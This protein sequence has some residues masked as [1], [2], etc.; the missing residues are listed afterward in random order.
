MRNLGVYYHLLLF[1]SIAPSTLFAD[2]P[3]DFNTQ[4]R[5][6][7]SNRCF[8]CH[9]PDEEERAADLR[10][11]T[12][13]GALDWAV[14][15]GEPEDSE[16]YSRIISDDEDIVMPPP[17]KGDPFSKEEAELIARWIREGANYSRHWAYVKPTRPGVPEGAHPVDHFIE[18]RLTKEGLKYSP[19]A[20]RRTLARRVSLDLTGLPPSP[21]EVDAF[22]ESKDP[23][24]YDKYVDDLLARNSFGEHWARMW[25]DL[26][27]YA[28]SAGYADDVPRTI[29]LYR[30]YVIRSFNE[31]KPFDQFTVEQ[32][33]GDLIENASEAQLIA[34]AFHR[35]TQTNN[36]G[37][38]NDEEFRNVAVVDRVNTTFAT[39]MG[40]TMACAQCHTHKYDPITHEEYYRVFA[41]LNQTQDSDKRD[42]RPLLSLFTQE[43]EREKDE[44][45]SQIA[46]LE[47]SLA[48]DK[49]DAEFL[50]AFSDWEK[51]LN[52]TSWKVL[53]PANVMATSGADLEVQD[54]DSVFASGAIAETEEYTLE[55]T[56]PIAKVTAV[57]LELLTDDR[58]GQS[59]PA[60]DRNLVLNEL[61][62]TSKSESNGDTQTVRGRFVRLE[63]PGKDRILHVQEIQ[64]F[65]VGENVAL[66]GRATQS[67]TG[68][69]G[70]AQIAIDGDV[71]SK[72]FSHTA[73][74]DP[75]PW[76]EVD[77]GSTQ[78]LSHVVVWNRTDNKLQSRLNGFRLIVLDEQRKTLFEKAFTTAPDR[79]LEIRFDGVRVAKF[80]EASASF[81]QRDFEV[82]KAIDGDASKNSGWA[83]A[84]GQGRSHEAVFRLSYPLAANE[85]RLTLK[86]NYPNHPIGRFRVFV[87]GSVNPNPALPEAIA[88]I[89][90]TPKSDR[91]SNAQS[92][93]HQY[94]AKYGPQGSATSTRIGEL[95]KKREAIKP[96]STVPI[97]REVAMA[98]RRK[99][100]IH[101]RGSYLNHGAEVQAGFP[102]SLAPSPDTDAPNRMTLANW[103]LS[104]DNP[105][106]ARVA[107]NRFWEK[108]FGIGIVAT[109]EEFGSQG[110]LPSH[111]ELLDWLAVEFRESG[112]DTKAMLKLLVTSRAYCQTSHAP[113]ELSARDPA[114]RMFARGP[115]VRL[116]AEMVRDQALAVSGLLS[117]KMYGPPVRPPQPDMGLKAAFGSGLDWN[118]SEGQDRFRR[119]IYT[120]WRRSNPYPSM[121]TFDA[122]NREVCTVRRD[123]TNTPLQALVT[124]NDPVYIEAA[125]SLARKMSAASEATDEK[126]RSGFKRC[127]SRLPSDI[128]LRRLVQ[129]F[130]QAKQR[131]G[132]DGELAEKMATDPIGPAPKGSDLVELAALTL[133]ANVL[134]NLDEILMKR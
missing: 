125:Q 16:V 31:N 128:E 21:E 18:R 39:W 81:E 26:A 133:T 77:L 49:V 70:L 3:V 126:I 105:L 5:P 71:E 80:S 106:T 13:D 38:T 108:L 48:V 114:N 32:L 117:S 130:E 111:P 115:R 29:W 34:T 67:T 76:W 88:K 22:V 93:L 72:S 109:S 87:T 53:K 55:A 85:L 78:D 95:R 63:L 57:K 127:L 61:E 50:A 104:E 60:R 79:E 94:F 101:L 36:E 30:D 14:V 98:E 86:Q 9:G 69:G 121:T 65:A 122:P 123:R 10:L 25:L 107:A 66:K 12:K 100:H 35:N 42:E 41:I 6:L 131:Y 68:F 33:A 134:L 103:L 99:T 89:V 75:S 7:F 56:S 11:D 2:E 116:S 59:G 96:E 37:G 51:S 97:L 58:L 113:K 129:F 84:G 45:D 120:T 17:G 4:I 73:K 20:D 19:E 83:I 24:A 1:L 118:T 124:L 119:G 40:T 62:L 8:A 54:D 43:Q 15:P 64:A 23:Q 52:S 47:K 92:E 102:V 27:R 28:D 112:W 91:D 74:D 90:A 44:L 46:S 82:S 110:E 132:K